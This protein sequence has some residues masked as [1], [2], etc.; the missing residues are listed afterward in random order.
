M[1]V[2]VVATIVCVNDGVHVIV[3]VSIICPVIFMMKYTM[4]FSKALRIMLMNLK[5]KN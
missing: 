2:L 4:I 1:V 5:T 3:L